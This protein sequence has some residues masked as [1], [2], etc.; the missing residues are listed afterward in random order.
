[1][2]D[3]AQVLPLIGFYN[4]EVEHY[5]FDWVYIL[6]SGST[7]CSDKASLYVNT[8]ALVDTHEDRESSG[9]N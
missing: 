5:L 2:C 1:M 4:Y 8:M 7:I 6:Y 3:R 9:E